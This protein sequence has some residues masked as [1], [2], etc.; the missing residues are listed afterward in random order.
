MTVVVRLITFA[1]VVG[2]IVF[3]I[4]HALSGPKTAPPV[5]PPYPCG[6]NNDCP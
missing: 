3:T 1:V 5:N 2:V 6:Q 4:H